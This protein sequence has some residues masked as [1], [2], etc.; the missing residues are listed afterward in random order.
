MLAT[1]A[2]GYNEALC[3]PIC[4]ICIKDQRD[5]G[6]AAGTAGSIRSAISTVGSTIYVIVLTSR[7]KETIPSQVPPA[8]IAAGLPASSVEAYMTAASAGSAAALEK[9]EGITPAIMAA[10]ARAFQVAYSDAYR[11]IFYASIAFGVIAIALSFFVPNVDDLLTEKVSTQLHDR[12][13][14]VVDE[15]KVEHFAI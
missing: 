6:A 12:G 4:T 9:I 8:V 13:N 3:L 5:I 15:E 10:G 14:E 2:I 1:T 7:L 11:T